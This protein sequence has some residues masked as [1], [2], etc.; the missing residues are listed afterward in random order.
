MILADKKYKKGIVTF[1]AAALYFILAV[2]WLNKYGDGTL[3][4]RY[5]N[6]IPAGDGNVF[7][8]IRTFITN[9]AY[10]ITQII[11]KDNIEFVISVAGA[12]A[13]VPFAVKKWQTLILF[14]PFILFN[15]LPDY[16]FFIFTASSH[17]FIL[18]IAA[19]ISIHPL[20]NTY[21]NPILC[22]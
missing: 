12:L 4:F 9:P 19:Y 20:P 6:V 7:G 14:G 22:A 18:Q 13:F 15:L 3:T 17:S 1:I 11:S 5:N 10:M 16:A 8:M 2:T 21:W